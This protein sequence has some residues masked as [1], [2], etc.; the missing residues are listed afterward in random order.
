[1]TE[2]ETMRMGADKLKLDFVTKRN[3]SEI[4]DK[5]SCAGG[6]GDGIVSFIYKFLHYFLR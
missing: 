6:V 2:L 1:M 4:H 3:C 5:G